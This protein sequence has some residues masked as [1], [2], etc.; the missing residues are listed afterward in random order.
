VRMILSNINDYARLSTDFVT[1]V[2]ELSRILSRT[3]RTIERCTMPKLVSK[4]FAS[5]AA[6]SLLE[7]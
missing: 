5:I 7:G 2:R 4:M 3:L 1:G 6:D